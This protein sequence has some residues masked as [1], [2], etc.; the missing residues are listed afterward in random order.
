VENIVDNFL[1][2]LDTVY[3]TFA[4]RGT[5][6]SVVLGEASDF[7]NFFLKKLKITIFA[8]NSFFYSFLH[9]FAHFCSFLLIFCSFFDKKAVFLTIVK[10]DEFK[11]SSKKPL[12]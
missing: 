7:F 3:G 1:T 6:Y 2:E 10:I 11:R 8:K 9:I 12:Q 4:E 5:T